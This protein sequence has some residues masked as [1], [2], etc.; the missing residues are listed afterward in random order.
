MDIDD[1]PPVG[2][3]ILVD[4]IESHKDGPQPMH[5]NVDIEV[6]RKRPSYRNQYTLFLEVDEFEF[7][8]QLIK[9]GIRKKAVDHIMS[10]NTIRSSLL[11]RHFNLAHTLANKGDNVE[12]DALG[13]HSVISTIDYDAGCSE[14]PCYWRD[15]INV[16]RDLLQN[17]TY[18]NGLIYTPSQLTD[19]FGERIYGELDTGDW[20]WNLQVRTTAVRAIPD[21]SS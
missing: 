4:K 7:A 6:G 11:N 20:W 1:G 16:V 8:F 15:P 5:S 13:K 17:P 10:L 21:F 9:H 12:P 3:L 19:T 14:T 2:T 18:Q